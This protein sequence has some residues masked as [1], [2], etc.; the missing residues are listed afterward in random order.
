MAQ[1]VDLAV[2]PDLSGTT[3][4]NH[5]RFPALKQVLGPDLVRNR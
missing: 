1:L 2:S 3:D 4:V 5:A